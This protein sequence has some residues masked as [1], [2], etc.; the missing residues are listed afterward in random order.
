[1]L[2]GGSVVIRYTLEILKTTRGLNWQHNMAIIQEREEMRT[3]QQ[4]KQDGW[5]HDM[6]EL[7]ITECRERANWCNETFGPRYDNMT[8]AGKWYGAQLPFQSGGVTPNRQFVFMFRDDKLY[9]MYRM[10]WPE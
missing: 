9:T 8:W 2:A 10:M 5:I 4:L 3:A 1:M 7:S 6:T